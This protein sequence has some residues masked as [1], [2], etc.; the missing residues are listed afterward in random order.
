MMWAANNLNLMSKVLNGISGIC[1]I[2]NV[3]EGI[4]F[5]AVMPGLLFDRNK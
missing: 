1:S 4:K 3:F 2:M 5:Y